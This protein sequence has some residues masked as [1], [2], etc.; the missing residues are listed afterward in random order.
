MT[1]G[2]VGVV[3]VPGGGPF[4]LG[5]GDLLLNPVQ[6]KRSSSALEEKNLTPS[7]VYIGGGGAVFFFF[8]FFFSLSFFF[9]FLKGEWVGGRS[10]EVV[11]I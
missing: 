11:S 2:R 9:I 5:D 10:A 8:F 1:R 7:M 4:F 3:V 6:T